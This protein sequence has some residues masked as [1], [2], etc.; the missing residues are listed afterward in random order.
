MSYVDSILQ[1]NEQVLATGKMHWIIY[2]QGLALL[3]LALAVLFIPLP[4]DMRFLVQFAAA[5]IGLLALALL[6]R[7]WVEQVTTEI[8]VTNFR[9]IQKRGLIRRVTGEMNMDKV[10]SVL[11]DQT[12][13][14]RILNYGTIAVRGTGSG[15]E[16][17]QHIARPLSLRSAIVVR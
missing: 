12:I 17:L 13:M 16:G 9:V 3:V 5:A 10:E 14:G 8:A 11:V 4:E 7:A 6:F 2:V 1:P 15:I